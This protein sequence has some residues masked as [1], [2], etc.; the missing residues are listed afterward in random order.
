MDKSDVA[1][2]ERQRDV[3]SP[4]L[5][6]IALDPLLRAL[7]ASEIGVQYCGIKISSL[8]YANDMIIVCRNSEQI[9]QALTILHEFSLVSGLSINMD[10][11]GIINKSSHIIQTLNSFTYLGITY[12][13]GFRDDSAIIKSNVPLSLIYFFF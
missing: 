1:P 6:N 12:T 13:N 3:I 8:A 11:S 7:H 2:I 9:E 10:K 4:L 5:F